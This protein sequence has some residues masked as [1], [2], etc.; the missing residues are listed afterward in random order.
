M[1]ILF[2]TPHQLWPVNSGA[3]LRNLYLAGALAERCSVT[4]LQIIQPDEHIV[5]EGQSAVFEQC[6][7]IEKGRSYTPRNI[8][9]GLLGPTPLTVLNYSSPEIS[10]VLA[11]LLQANRFDSIQLESSHLSSYLGVIRA[12]R[13]Q[14]PVLLDWHN[15]ESELMSRYAA[16]TPNLPRKL[17]G[18]RTATLLRKLEARLLSGC[19]C[20]T[21]V[22][23]RERQKLLQQDPTVQVSVIPNG[24]DVEAFVPPNTQDR[25]QQLLFV[26]SM[27]YHANVDAVTWF[28]KS[29]W[30]LI[31]RQHPQ[32]VFKIVGRSPTLAVRTLA[33]DRVHITGTVDDVRPLYSK[34]LAVIVPLRVGGGARLKILEAMAM[35][36]P[37][38]ST[39]LGA[40]GISV[41]DGE[42][43]LL[44]DLP[45]EM[46]F[47]L[48]RI[49]SQP[50]LR[51]ALISSARR[52]VLEH[53]DWSS[54]G[55]R[56]FDIHSKLIDATTTRRF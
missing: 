41:H 4:L 35:G 12:M 51:Q 37:V 8:L 9:K 47:A 7:A 52:L 38:I 55:H 20:H 29:A 22:S 49:V 1:R 26:G 28:V 56:L 48:H 6:L 54:I 34:A 36:V 14:P 15:I 53:Y 25:A 27:D 3:R 39:A 45:E 44:A 13:P 40:E 43:I 19:D 16:Q 2:F 33:S 32:L 50:A 42:N 21:V 18:H 30:P 11:N 23:E 31:S 46:A 10:S 5:Q 17:I 24:V